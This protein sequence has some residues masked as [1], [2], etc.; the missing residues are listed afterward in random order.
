M[1]GGFFWGHREVDEIT[2]RIAFNVVLS[3]LEIA[4]AQKHPHIHEGAAASSVLS[5][6][7]TGRFRGHLGRYGQPSSV[8]N[9]IAESNSQYEKQ[10]EQGI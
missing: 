8:S 9:Q 3:A 5:Y 2:V 10:H 4:I 6:S 1:W 7:V